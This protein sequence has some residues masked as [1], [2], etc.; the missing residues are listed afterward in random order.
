MINL[1]KLLAI[2]IST[3][4]V[5]SLTSCSPKAVNTPGS[6]KVKVTVW[7]IDPKAVGSG[8][9]ELLAE[10][11]KTY[12]NIELI[13]QI[14]PGSG[15]YDTQDLSK[16]TAA[17]AAGNPADVVWLNAPFIM[18]VA[19]RGV[20]TPLDDLIKSANLDMSGYYDYTVKEMTFQGKTWGLPQGV[21]DRVLYW[22]K[23]LFKAAGLD[24]E[25]PP[26]TWDDL[27]AYSKLLT[28]M[29]GKGNYSQIGFI[30]NYGNSWLYLYSLQ[31]NGKFLSDDG[32]TCLLNSSQNVEALNFMVK[33]YDILGGAT[34]INAYSS[35]FQA[36]ASDPFITGKVAMVINGNW[37][38]SD[39]ARYAPDMN[40]GITM[41]PTPTGADFKTWSGG[42][43]WGIPKGAKHTKEGFEVIK[44]LTTESSKSQ[45]TGVKSFNDGKKLTTL[46]G[47][48]AYKAINDFLYKT[49]VEPLTNQKLK[50]S[51]KFCI[52]ALKTSYSLPVSPVG[53]LLWSN[54]AQAID[55][56]IYHKSTAK[57]ALDIGTKN[58]QTELDK[59]WSA[60]PS[61]N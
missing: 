29:D 6:T 19:S 52:D 44:W 39:Y 46:P 30:P 9:K 15:G 40:Y 57:D 31:N 51:Y 41:A 61:T 37:A 14:M 26:K 23:D 42:W 50:D 7:G 20:L 54:H 34:K 49:Y 55:A 4:I 53:Q 1:K 5:L 27:L 59:F 2:V 22:N 45:M 33:G 36:G 35:T 24:P 58:V 21:D 8:N 48:A 32:K 17:I 56:A 18:E 12:P 11:A 16:L 3:V 10:F 28:K 43:A 38:L 60:H 47:L 13:P 25:K